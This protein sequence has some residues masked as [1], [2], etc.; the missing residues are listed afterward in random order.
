MFNFLK[1]QIPQNRTEKRQRER[2]EEIKLL[3]YSKYT[4]D[5]EPNTKRHKLD[6]S[7]RRTIT[8]TL[9]NT[10]TIDIP[11]STRG[12]RVIVDEAEPITPISSISKSIEKVFRD[13]STQTDSSPQTNVENSSCEF[14]SRSFKNLSTCHG[15]T[16]F[17]VTYRDEHVNNLSHQSYRHKMQQLYVER[18]KREQR[19]RRQLE[20]ENSS[21]AFSNLLSRP[22]MN[23]I[24]SRE[25]RAGHYRRPR[26]N[27]LKTIDEN[28]TERPKFPPL[29]SL[30]SKSPPIN[31]SHKPSTPPI[32]PVNITNNRQDDELSINDDIIFPILE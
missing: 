26:H 12:R 14:C 4:T 3:A 8:N 10:L 9:T 32:N 11:D 19:N 30:N 17:L 7:I 1:K 25:D 28:Q 15:C 29:M 5:D 23:S 24:V 21:F 2:E 31:T 22:E 20:A 18:E 16:R 27:A 6:L 13:S